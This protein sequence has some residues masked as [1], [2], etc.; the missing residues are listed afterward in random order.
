MS[1]LDR[2][3]DHREARLCTETHRRIEEIVDAEI[4]DGRKR[5]QLERHV[6]VCV[7]CGGSAASLRELKGAIARVGREPD[8]A[9]KA[10]LVVLVDGIR[11][12][13]VEPEGD[14]PQADDPRAAV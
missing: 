3:R 14:D 8:A 5:A 6:E 2:W 12:G 7:P 1:W 11:A 10:R 13:A 9:V 4:P